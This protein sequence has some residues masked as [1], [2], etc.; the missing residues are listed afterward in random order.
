[1]NGAMAPFKTQM[2][3]ENE[4]YRNAANSVGECPLFKKLPKNPEPPE[5]PETPELPAMVQIPKS[6][7]RN[8]YCETRASFWGG[9]SPRMV[10]KTPHYRATCT[11]FA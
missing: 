10:H 4:K 1:M 2:Q 9:Q 3:H 8:Y 11:E 6:V 7:N 5:A